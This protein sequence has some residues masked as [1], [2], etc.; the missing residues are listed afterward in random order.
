MQHQH[1]NAAST[2][3]CSIDMDPGSID[4]DMRDGHRHEA[5]TRTYSRDVNIDIDMYMDMDMDTDRDMD[6]IDF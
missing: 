6:S 4:T 3:T 5:C 1:G 2:G